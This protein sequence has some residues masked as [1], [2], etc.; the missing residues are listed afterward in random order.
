MRPLLCSKGNAFESWNRRPSLRCRG[1][2]NVALR[3][4]DRQFQQPNID[5]AARGS[6]GDNG[7]SD[8][9]HFVQRA[10]RGDGDGGGNRARRRRGNGH[11][12]RSGNPRRRG[13][14]ARGRRRGVSICGSNRRRSPGRTARRPAGRQGGQ[15]DRRGSRGLGRQVDS[16]GLLL[17]LDLSGFFLRGNS[18]TRSVG[19]ILSHNVNFRPHYGSAARVSIPFTAANAR[20]VQDKI[21]R[22]L[23]FLGVTPLSPRAGSCIPGGNLESAL[24]SISFIQ[25]FMSINF[26]YNTP[27]AFSAPGGAGM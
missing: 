22:F 18:A 16:N 19:D 23:C 2:F 1:W 8:G 3:T 20:P 14:R 12:A 17:G 11:R 24:E 13:D 25:L 9:Q 4:C 6:Q 7:R 15:L 21:L 26:I 5:R 27:A 10:N